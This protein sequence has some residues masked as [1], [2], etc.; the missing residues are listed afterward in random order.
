MG[1]NGT[2]LVLSVIFGAFGSGYF[3]YGKK[4][5]HLSALLCG[6]ALCVFPWFVSSTFM[7]VVVGVLLMVAPFLIGG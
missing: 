4:Q 6:I 5:G 3:V 7:I 2:A 1:G